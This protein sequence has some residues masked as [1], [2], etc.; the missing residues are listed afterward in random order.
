[1]NRKIAFTKNPRH[2]MQT[3][4]YAEAFATTENGQSKFRVEP[5]Q[6]YFS[7]YDTT[8]VYES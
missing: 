6:L 8:H 5:E 7:D 2:I 3:L 4:S 1:M